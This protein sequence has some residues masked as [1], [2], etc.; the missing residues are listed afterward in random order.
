MKKRTFLPLIFLLTF[1]LWLPSTPAAEEWVLHKTITEPGDS[2]RAL[3]FSASGS[4]LIV[5]TRYNDTAYN[6]QV[7]DG[8]TFAYLHGS[9]YTDSGQGD[10]V[11]GI[12]TRKGWYEA[13]IAGDFSKVYLYNTKSDHTLHTFNTSSRV[14]DL[15]YRPDGKRLAAGAAN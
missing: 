8:N 5:G 2:V 3:A 6:V 14:E 12:A 1:T 9:D 4:R 11:T 7:Y 10:P 13:S 15:A